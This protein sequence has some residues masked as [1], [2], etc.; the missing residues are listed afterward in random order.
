M[1]VATPGSMDWSTPYEAT[2]D[3]GGQVFAIGDGAAFTFVSANGASASLSVSDVET[4]LFHVVDDI[5]HSISGSAASLFA[6]LKALLHRFDG[7]LQLRIGPDLSGFVDIDAHGGTVTT[8]NGVDL[9]ATHSG[10]TFNLL[11]GSDVLFYV[12][13]TSTLTVNAGA[14]NDLVFG[15]SP[16]SS[17]NLYLGSGDDTGYG[18]AKD[19]KLFGQAGNDRLYGRGGNDFLNGGAGNDWL[20]GG[21]GADRLTGG[22]GADRFV[23]GAGD[24]GLG[25]ARDT[26]LDF[27]QGLD[28]I[29]L[30][31]TDLTT[32]IG[33]QKFDG[34]AGQF[35]Y[36]ES[37]NFT[38]LQGDT[39]GDR[40]SDFEIV[41]KGHIALTTNDVLTSH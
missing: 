3:D 18:D 1:S 35:R 25:K 12:A 7:L 29:D 20:D 30:T 23:F 40:H 22:A 24:T 28:L 19:D 14:G 9:V 17:I 36:I 32:F 27:R 41:M 26:V 21:K 15:Y 13:P 16:S 34:H 4:G 10:G 6:K 39:N 11:G 5:V 33:N 38:I 37:G 2:A 31:R 8:T